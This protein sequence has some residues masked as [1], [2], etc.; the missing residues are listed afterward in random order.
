M[1][2]WFIFPKTTFIHF[3]NFNVQCGITYIFG[4]LPS[5]EFYINIGVTSFCVIF[6]LS[7]LT[8]VRNLTTDLDNFTEFYK[9]I[10]RDRFP[11]NF[12]NEWVMPAGSS[13]TPSPNLFAF[14]FMLRPFLPF[15]HGLGFS[16]E[17]FRIAGA[18]PHQVE[19]TFPGHLSSLSIV[20]RVRVK[21]TMLFY[22][23]RFLFIPLPIFPRYWLS[24]YLRLLICPVG[25]FNCLF[26]N[27]F[28]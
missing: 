23:A 19:F 1:Y 11:L 12:G 21:Y 10:E 26:A 8:F 13:R 2:H 27:K 5:V 9:F 22:F 25:V 17:D 15:K 3:W 14:V 28:M 16:I 18:W 6:V 7:N 20:L 4:N 24:F